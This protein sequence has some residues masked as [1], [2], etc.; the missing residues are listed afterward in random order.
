MIA[1]VEISAII[2]NVI[3]TEQKHRDTA[4]GKGR[5]DQYVANENT[6]FMA[7]RNENEDMF[8]VKIKNRV[9]YS[10]KNIISILNLKSGFKSEQYYRRYSKIAT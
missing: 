9:R 5:L 6:N 2:H 3:V 1:V 10:I 8:F 7:L 4:P